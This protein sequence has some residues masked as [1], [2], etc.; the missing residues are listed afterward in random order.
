MLAVL[1]H[2]FHLDRQPQTQDCGDIV[3]RRLWRRRT[4]EWDVTPV[5]KEKTYSYIPE[6]LG[7]IFKK[8]AEN[9]TSI[10]EAQV[11]VPESHPSN[12]LPTIA[13]T[14]PPAT[15]ELVVKKKSRFEG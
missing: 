11:C 8:H 5:K 4:K 3:Y 9:E 2:N 1:D 6:L 14:V 12:I 7:L 13:P 10:R 15:A